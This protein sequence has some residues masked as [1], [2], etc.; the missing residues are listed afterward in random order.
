MDFS[1]H[2][3]LHGLSTVQII[4]MLKFPF[5]S[6]EVMRFNTDISPP[7][8]AMYIRLLRG[9]LKK[10]A[11]YGGTV[12]TTQKGNLPRS[13]CRE[14]QK[15]FVDVNRYLYYMGP[16]RSEEEFMELHVIRLVAQKTGYLR[17]YKNKFHLTKKG[18]E[19]AEKGVSG[20]EF[21]RILE[22]YT[23]WFNWSYADFA[24]ETDLLQ[25]TFSFTLYLLQ[26]YGDEYR[27]ASY[28]AALTLQAFPRLLQN[29]IAAGYRHIESPEE[30]FE[31]VYT[32]RMLKRFA[33][34]FGF[35]EMNGP[36][37]VPYEENR[38]VRKT[39]FLDEFIWF[40]SER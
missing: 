24:V 12:R 16:V 17:K 5:E 22:V 31:F 14:L 7:Q 6:P 34:A 2:P 25:P 8:D 19:L 10:I 9:L 20:E 15:E 38:M 29:V 37:E 27:P 4:E 35:A 40:P 13:L 33:V 26:L 32:M 23:M 18:K 30:T 3:F 1:A 36:R 21:L 28:Y 39:T 11:L